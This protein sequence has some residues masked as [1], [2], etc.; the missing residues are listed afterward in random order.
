M[1]AASAQTRYM[2]SQSPWRKR[3]R[4]GILSPPHAFRLNR[5]RAGSLPSPQSRRSA[6]VPC[7]CHSVDGLHS[8]ALAL[9][10]AF[11]V[12][13]LDADSQ[14]SLTS[15]D[16]AVA[17][18]STRAIEPV[19]KPRIGATKDKRGTWH[20]MQKNEDQI[21][22]KAGFMKKD[23]VIP[24]IRHQTGKTTRTFVALDKNVS[25]FLKG[26]GGP[27]IQKGELSEVNVMNLIRDRYGV[28]TG[29]TAAVAEGDEDTAAV[30]EQQEEG[31]TAAAAEGE[32]TPDPMLALDEL[33]TPVPKAKS[34]AKPK[35]HANRARV[36]EV[37]MPLR[38][39]CAATDQGK[40][41]VIRIYRRPV[42]P[43][44]R[45][46]TRECLYM[47]L[48]HMDWLL[49]YAADELHFQGITR[50]DSR[51]TVDKEPN[52][53]AVADVFLKWNFGGK[54]WHAEFVA[55]PCCGATLS[56]AVEH[57]TSTQRAKLTCDQTDA[58]AAPSPVVQ[59]KNNAKDLITRWCTAILANEAD[60][61]AREWEVDASAVGG[62]AK[63]RRGTG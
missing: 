34:P 9:S 54:E 7:S 2:H 11:S 41:I 4:G 53:P 45:K 26:T 5:S 47:D 38:P 44:Q 57:L 32:A 10:L 63:K 21:I 16:T 59:L 58:G 39:P 29:T 24:V 61:F 27:A 56:F 6:A 31:E 19:S 13:M 30:A 55:G 37:T 52:C 49:A 15:D 51:P 35:V 8:V 12:A 33:C 48:D 50:T 40:T 28:V 22:L 62:P 1:F 43:T 17:G 23:E 3:S 14:S 46:N 42:P 18:N 60:E 20:S 36:T 25:W